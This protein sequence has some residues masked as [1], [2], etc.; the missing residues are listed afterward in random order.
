MSAPGMLSLGRQPA[1]P[2]AA[3]GSASLGRGGAC[4]VRGS[5][6]GWPAGAAAGEMALLVAV[7]PQASAAQLQA[8]TCWQA[9]SAATLRLR[10][11]CPG[12]PQTTRRANA[13]R[14][15]S[16]STATAQATLTTALWKCCAGRG[17]AA[18]AA[19]VVAPGRPSMP[20]LRGGEDGWGEAG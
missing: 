14:R 17:S 12:S 6:A 4:L 10:V 3:S 9:A 20:A 19:A 5:A 2:P 8:H 13:T 15:V 18:A 1:P 16:T 7:F 11:L